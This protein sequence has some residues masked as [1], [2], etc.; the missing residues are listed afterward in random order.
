MSL[1]SGNIRKQLYNTGDIVTIKNNCK[2]LSCV[3][4]DEPK[5]RDWTESGEHDYIYPI[6]SNE[7]EFKSI[8]QERIIKKI[9][10]DLILIS[11]Q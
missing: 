5:W 6:K 11:N 3:I 4:K 2:I 9:G 10:S 7:L 1:S 8:C